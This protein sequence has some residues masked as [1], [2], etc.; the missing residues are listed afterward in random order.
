MLL[1]AILLAAYVAY[2]ILEYR[3]HLRN[4]RAIPI[5]VHVNGTRGKSSVTRLI[6]A[7]LRAGGIRTVAKTTGS[8]ARYIHPDG[9]EEPIPRAGPPNVREQLEIVRRARQEGARAIV[10]ECMAVM[11]ELQ[12]VCEQRILRSTI[13]VITN[14]RPDHLDVMGPTVRD[15]AI[16]LSGTTPAGGVLFT[17]EHERQAVLAAAARERRAEFREVEPAAFGTDITSGFGHVEHADNIALSLAVCERLGVPRETALSGMRTAAPDVGALTIHR[18]REAGKEIEFVNGFAA[19]DPESTAAIWRVIVPEGDRS[20]TVIGVVSM[21]ADRHDRARQY[22]QMLGSDL[23][24]DRF[25]LAGALTHPVLAGARRR[26]VPDEA[27]I[28]MAGCSAEQIYAKI[29][30]FTEARS[31]VVGVGNIG[32]V[33]G[34]LVGLVKARSRRA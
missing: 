17:S 10:M 5:R 20:R 32:G 2:G 14:A 4:L 23:K 16:A 18:V 8:A 6:A 22:G 33:G 30:E 19:N 25:I 13:G 31:L 7:G 15:V 24:A 21:R 12:V 34:E 29:L 3:A 9:T 1:V 27:L 28:D 11:P 26:G